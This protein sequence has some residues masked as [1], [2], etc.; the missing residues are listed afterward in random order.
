MLSSSISAFLLYASPRG[1]RP[2]C[3]AHCG[4]ILVLFVRATH[5]PDDFFESYLSSTLIPPEEIFTETDE[6]I[7]PRRLPFS[8]QHPGRKN[9]YPCLLPT[10][11]PTSS[12]LGKLFLQRCSPEPT[13]LVTSVLRKADHEEVC[14]HPQSIR[15]RIPNSLKNM[16]PARPRRSRTAWL[17]VNHP[18]KRG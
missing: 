1:T 2:Q 6:V 7:R 12:M 16:F 18:Y 11:H 4:A 3:R 9:V 5:I 10:T 8:L 13:R 15:L 17:R 14:E